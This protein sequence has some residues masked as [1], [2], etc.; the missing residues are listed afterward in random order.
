MASGLRSR[1]GGWLVGR[2]SVLGKLREWL[3]ERPLIITQ[4]TGI[5][6]AGGIGNHRET[7]HELGGVSDRAS[8]KLALDLIKS[9]LASLRQL[10]LSKLTGGAGQFQLSAVALSNS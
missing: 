9:S 3:E 8:L 4:I 10:V 7:T 1:A 6:F 2:E 5:G